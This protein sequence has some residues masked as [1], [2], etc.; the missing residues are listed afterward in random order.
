MMI[1]IMIILF[2]AFSSASRVISA[3]IKYSVDVLMCVCASFV[4]S[5]LA[6]DKVRASTE[7]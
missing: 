6:K 1:I 7:S 4:S 5:P 3:C 2:A